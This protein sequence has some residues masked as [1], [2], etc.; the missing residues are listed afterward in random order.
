MAARYPE[1]TVD[2]LLIG[3]GLAAATAAEEIR[4]RD[5]TGR[6]LLISDERQWPYHRPPLSKEYLRAE[7]DAEGLYGHGGVYVQRPDWYRARRIEVVR[8]VE[9][10]VLNTRARTICCHDGRVIGFRTALLATGGRP[11]LLQVP[12]ANLPEVHVLR[13]LSNAKALRERLVKGLRVV[14]VGAGFIGLECAASALMRGA[15]VTIIDSGERVWPTMLPPELSA[16]LMQ[17][18]EQRGA[19]FYSG[20][21]AQEFIG[22]NGHLTRVRIRPHQGSPKEIP[23]DLAIVGIGIEL[24]TEL[25]QTAG[26]EV[27]SRHGIV[28]NEHL[29]TRVA[30]IFAAGDVAAYPD[31]KVGRMHFEHWEHA[32]ATAQI[33]A[34]N[35][36]GG[37]VPYR[38]VPYF[39]SDQYDLSLQML[40]YPSTDARVVIRGDLAQ[41]VFTAFY[42][43]H[44]VLKA[45][46]MVNDDEHLG[47]LTDLI[48]AAVSIPRGP[49]R[50]ADPAFDLSS[51]RPAG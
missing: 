37:D 43:L 24:N 2:Y 31:P 36:L 46:F 42:V 3:G 49:L 6:I 30:G 10:S 34:A 22:E 40:G 8:A 9:V 12:G 21:R 26:L 47:L 35:M 28:V 38:H 39:F 48:A 45:A 15:E 14:V 41:G 1:Q 11:R 51:L 23:C 33:A 13:T 5:A 25:A 20:Y 17:Q 16:F 50:L 29:E 32:I 44:D 27:D 18:H 7:V 4:K 19:Q